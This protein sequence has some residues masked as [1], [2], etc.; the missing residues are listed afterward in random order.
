MVDPILDHFTPY[1]SRSNRWPFWPY[2]NTTVNET[3]LNISQLQPAKFLP[4]IMEDEIKQAPVVM[5][6]GTIVGILNERD[7]SD[8]AAFT[9][10]PGVMVPAHGHSSGYHVVYTSADTNASSRY[11]R[12]FDIDGDGDDLRSSTGTSVATVA[13]V[14]P[15][16]IVE[17][18]IFSRAFYEQHR[19]LEQQPKVRLLSGGRRVIIPCIT[20]EERS[21]YESDLVKVSDTSGDWDPVNNPGTTYPGRWKKFD[22]AGAVAQIPLLVGRCIRRIVI[23]K[24]T[25]STLLSTDIANGVTLTEINSDEDYD[26]I[27]R[28]QTVPGLRLAGS[29]TQGMLPA[30]MYARSDSNGYYYALDIAI[31]VMGL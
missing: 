3:A 11:K 4:V 22:P 8:L 30:L 6:P 10:K 14:F 2:M 27:K 12:V 16:G 31:S 17:Q 29:G 23:A 15:L 18:P 7:H 5:Y 24:G 19:N 13:T 9:D 21:I 26:T 20:S 1:G 25:G 28:V